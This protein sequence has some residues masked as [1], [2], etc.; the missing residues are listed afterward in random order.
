MKILFVNSAYYPQGAGS[1]RSVRNL[2]EG[3][4]A[5]GHKAVVATLNGGTRKADVVNGVTIHHLPIRNLYYMGRNKQPAWKRFLWHAIDMFNPLA[6]YDVYKLL[7]IER[8]DVINTNV[9]AG[10]S[11]GI[12]YVARWMGIPLVHTMRDYY[13]MCPQ[14]A[15][16]RNGS[17]CKG[18]CKGCKPFFRVRRR[19][20]KQASMF[21]ANSQ[22]VANRHT[23]NGFNFRAPCHVQF[24]VNDD[25]TIAAPRTYPQD[26]PFTI[27]FIGRLDPS[28]GVEVLLRAV[29]QLKLPQWKLI[30][31]G[32][33][34]TPYTS[35]LKAAHANPH[36]SFAGHMDADAFY[37]SIDLLVCP[38][39]YAEPLPRVVYEAYRA[40]LPVIVSDSGGTPEIVDGGI[41]GFIY[42]AQE[43]EKLAEYITLLAASPERYNQFSRQAAIKAKAFQ[44]GRGTQE[45]IAK[46]E[47]AVDGHAG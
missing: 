14:N 5:A 41:T 31:A 8:P 25:D 40:A 30:I 45:F 9:I 33:G 15:M 12:F 44:R 6:M 2:A 29:E 42:P 23:G 37:A 32:E 36:I 11:T 10:F 35:R 43:P 13:L 3:A 19:A 20:A 26:R 47:R 4:Q 7:R 1:G 18:V 16:F 21:L 46:L 38:S 34:G 22:F 27:G 39:L 17:S 28:K 24:N